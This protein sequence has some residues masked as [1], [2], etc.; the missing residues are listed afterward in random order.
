MEEDRRCVSSLFSQLF[1]VSSN[2]YHSTFRTIDV[3]KHLSYRAI[4]PPGGQRKTNIKII[5]E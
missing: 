4:L 2:S 5:F 1:L 3:K